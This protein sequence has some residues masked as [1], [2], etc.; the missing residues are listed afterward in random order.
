MH[1]QHIRGSDDHKEAGDISVLAHISHTL[2]L[3]DLRVAC[4]EISLFFVALF[5]ML[6]TTGP[7]LMTELNATLT[8]MKE[9]SLLGVTILAALVTALNL[10]LNPLMLVTLRR[11]T[12]IQ[13]TTKVL[14][15]SL[16]VSD[17]CNG[18]FSAFRLPELAT[19]A[20]P[21]GDFL[22]AASGVLTY[23]FHVLSILSLLVLTADRYL[24][25]AYPL[26]YP[27]L[28][29]ESRIKIVVGIKWVASVTLC[30]VLFG[31]LD[32]K[33]VL[34]DRYFR[35]CVWNPYSDWQ[36]YA[37]MA[38]ILVAF[39]AIHILYMCIRRIALRHARQIAVD[40]QAGPEGRGGGRASIARSTT[41]ILIITTT[42]MLTWWPP[43]VIYRYLLTNE[44]DFTT[45]Y[46]GSISADI[47][48]ISNSW[49]NVIIYYLRNNDL[50]QALHR[51]FVAWYQHLF[52]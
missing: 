45:L 2:P 46:H 17:L 10:L 42:L 33:K 7:T 31:I 21:L 35:L 3:E 47:L 28:V 1:F 43:V 40:N 4:H 48:L 12:S 36:T 15:A 27:T 9:R 25:I 50:R 51:L 34:S 26:R 32:H 52:H 44:E 18:I 37:F 11:V 5:M 39:F 29:T 19:G 20:W 23:T 24:A 8:P 6:N 41:T 14:M 38:L 22:C 30:T 16:T 49:L 13:P